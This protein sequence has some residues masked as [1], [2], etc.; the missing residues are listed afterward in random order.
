MKCSWNIVAASGT[1]DELSEAERKEFQKHLTT[2]DECAK[3]YEEINL[4]LASFRKC[5][6]PKPLSPLETET[7]IFRSTE[8]EKVSFRSIFTTLRRPV[9]AT[10]VTI[11]ILT[12][13][14]LVAKNIISP[15]VEDEIAEQIDFLENMDV[16]EKLVKVVDNVPQ[17]QS[18]DYRGPGAWNDEGIHG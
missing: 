14:V 7:L 4:L 15:K 1:W 16:I 5:P 10:V 17:D 8:R 3:I 11:L 2:C 18:F 12:T 13:G 6:E 9:L